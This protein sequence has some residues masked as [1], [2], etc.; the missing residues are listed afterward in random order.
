[1][2]VAHKVAGV[3]LAGAVLVSQV[4]GAVFL[5][6]RDSLF[7]DAYGLNEFSAT[8]DGISFTIKAKPGDSGLW[9]DSTDGLGIQHDYENDEIEGDETL[10]VLFHT[11][12]NLQGILITDLFNEH[13]YLETGVYS[14][15]TDW[16]KFYAA[17]DQLLGQSN[18]ELWIDAGHANLDFMFFQAPGHDIPGQ[19]H[20]FAL[21]G[22]EVS[23]VPL[24]AAFWLFVSGL[25]ALGG[26]KRRKTAPSRSI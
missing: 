18:G 9:W 5:D 13:G 25:L 22:L 23:A 17:Q 10:A 4:A 1:M 26:L 2:G 19:N 20:E 24:P 15:N 11:P 3:F 7:S 12:V 6:F 8:V 21:A 16:H 14:S